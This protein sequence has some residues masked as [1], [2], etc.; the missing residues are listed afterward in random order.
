MMKDSEINIFPQTI[1]ELERFIDRYQNK[2]VHHAFFKLGSKEEAEDVVQEVIIKV[3]KERTKYKNLESPVSYV[4]RMVS[5]ACIDKIRIRKNIEFKNENYLKD[6]SNECTN[7]S[8]TMIIEKEE[9][10]R[11][12][13]ILA[14]IPIE[15]AEVIH[16][17]VIDE[18]SFVEIAK[19]L[20]VSTTTVKSR[21]KYGINK[22]KSIYQN[23][24][25]VQNEL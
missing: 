12:S 9:H 6:I 7:D 14:K 21:F 20:E 3:F 19:I 18:M 22:L 2:L 16:Q 24:K 25:E 10:K 17:R 23:Y 1:E 13:E 5:N 8:T 4:F 15:Q 11:I